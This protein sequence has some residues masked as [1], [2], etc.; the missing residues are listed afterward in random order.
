M[1]VKVCSIGSHQIPI[2]ILVLG[3]WCRLEL[4][5]LEM[6]KMMSEEIVITLFFVFFHPVAKNLS[7]Y[8]TFQCYIAPRV[9]LEKKVDA[10]VTDHISLQLVV[11]VQVCI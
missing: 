9:L 10:G 11:Y 3:E 1:N 2:I 4:S 8:L 7:G 5:Y 6:E